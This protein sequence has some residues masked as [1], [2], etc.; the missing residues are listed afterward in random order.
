MSRCAEGTHELSTFVVSSSASP[1]ARFAGRF[2]E[3][4]A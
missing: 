2:Q 3:G 4:D 1:K